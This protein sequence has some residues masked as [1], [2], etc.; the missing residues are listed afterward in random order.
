MLESDLSDSRA[1]L[2]WGKALCA[3]AEL[4][5][6]VALLPA[7]E[8]P[9]VQVVPHARRLTCLVGCFDL[10]TPA[11]GV[12]GS[13]AETAVGFRLHCSGQPHVPPVTHE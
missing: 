9:D 1:A 13:R 7:D 12:A 3:R 2:N 4:A 5:S 11:D 10:G 6:N 8:E